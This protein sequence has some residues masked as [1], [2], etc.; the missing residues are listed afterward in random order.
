MKYAVTSTFYDDGTAKV[1]KPVPCA[2]DAKP[3][4]CELRTR[5][6]YTDVFDTWDEAWAFYRNNKEA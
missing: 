3:C 2:D 4:S 1:G 6:I 5:D